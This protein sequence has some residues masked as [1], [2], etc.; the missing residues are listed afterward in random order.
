LLGVFGG[1]A[2]N[3]EG[4]V[5]ALT[6][7]WFGIAIGALLFWHPRA[8]GGFSRAWRRYITRPR[9]LVEFF[10]LLIAIFAFLAATAAAIFSYQQI[11]IAD[12][13]S[14]RQLRAYMLF[15]WAGVEEKY[16][17]VKFR[18]R[19][20]T[21]AF[22]TQIT[23][24]SDFMTLSEVDERIHEYGGTKELGPPI[25]IG[26]D[27][28]IDKRGCDRSENYARSG[29]VLYIWAAVTFLDVFQRCQHT[30]VLLK[31]AGDLGF[32][33]ENTDTTAPEIF[34]KGHYPF[35]RSYVFDKR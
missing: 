20:E 15:E 17:T 35:P 32:L 5:L 13:S 24:T 28:M 18:N 33:V 34:C 25:D 16:M 7:L 12:S 3:T 23:C 11:I 6:G 8:K 9:K 1:I 4:C 27:Q 10:G 21:P 2:L 19:G 22:A 31:D 14:K 29:T 26:K 30:W